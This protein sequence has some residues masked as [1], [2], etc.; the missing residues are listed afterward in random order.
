V[1]LFYNIV[2]LIHLL[3]AMLF[4]GWGFAKLF[5]VTPTKKVIGESAYVALQSA[6]SKK[7]WKIYPPNMLVLLTTG[8]IMFFRY[9][10]FKD[11]VFT[12]PFQTILIIKALIA[13]GIGVKVVTSITKRLFFKYKN[14]QDLNPVESNAYYYI[15]AAG[16]TIVIL[17][18]VM[19]MV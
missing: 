9:I 16:I 10:S 1:E 12:T 14:S 13:Y 2:L 19:Y 11:G 17:A 3:S 8:T 7:V 15:I 5:V 4:I 6:L 18:K